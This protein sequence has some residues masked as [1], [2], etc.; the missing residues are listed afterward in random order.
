MARQETTRIHR[1]AARAGSLVS[2][3][4]LIGIALIVVGVVGSMMK[5]EVPRDY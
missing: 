5:D 4:A 2:I 1:H 3:L